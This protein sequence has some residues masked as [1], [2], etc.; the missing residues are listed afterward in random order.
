MARGNT[1]YICYIRL[2]EY[3]TPYSSLIT[4]ISEDVMRLTEHCY[5]QKVNLIGRDRVL[6]DLVGKLMLLLALS[7]VLRLSRTLSTLITI[8]SR[9]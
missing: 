4:Q 8:N 3:S 1:F 9:S 6:E 5:G 2:I 7:T